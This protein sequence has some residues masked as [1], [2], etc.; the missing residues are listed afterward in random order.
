MPQSAGHLNE[1]RQNVSQPSA[2]H[3][4][5][6]RRNGHCLLNGIPVLLRPHQ[7]VDLEKI[8]QTGGDVT[9]RP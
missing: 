6:E 9:N 3:P 5:A 8:P 2:N 7:N 1:L 4:S